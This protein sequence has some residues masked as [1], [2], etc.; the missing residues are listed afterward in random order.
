MRPEPVDNVGFPG[1]SAQY[2][3]QLGKCLIRGFG[4]F[5]L[6]ESMDVGMVNPGQ[7]AQ[8]SQGQLPSITQPP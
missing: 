7:L 4:F 8:F 3:E 6:L 2:P 5:S 1:I